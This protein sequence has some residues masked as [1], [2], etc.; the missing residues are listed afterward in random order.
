MAQSGWSAAFYPQQIV[1]LKYQQ[2]A[3]LRNE[4]ISDA[5]VLKPTRPF[6]ALHPIKISQ[7]SMPSV[8]KMVVADDVEIPT[9]FRNG[10][11]LT[12]YLGSGNAQILSAFD[13]G[14]LRGIRLQMPEGSR[15]YGAG[16]RATS[17][18]RTG[19]RVS[20]YN[21]PQYGYE[22]GQDQ[23]NYSVPMVITSAGYGLFFDNPSK[24]YIDF[25]KTNAGILEAG[26]ESGSIDVYVIPGPEIGKVVERFSLLTGRQ[27]L[28]PRWV[29]GNFVSRFGYR[30]ETQLMDV[31]QK[32]E[33]AQVP[34]D[35][36]IIDVFWFGDS[37]QGTLGNLAWQ[38]NHWPAP[39]KMMANLKKKNLNTI[40]VTEPFFLK[41][42]KNFTSSLPFLATDSTNKPFMLTDFYFGYGG[43]LDIF[44]PAARQWFWQFYKQQTDAGVAGWW[45][46]LGEPEKHPAS[47][48]HQITGLGVNRK[49]SA[50]EVH[51]L[52]G[53]RWSEMLFS[54]WQ[55]QYPNRR[56]FFLNR[57][58]FAGSQRFSIFPWTG[59]VSRSW[60]GFRAQLP[61]LQ[62]MSLSSVPYIHSDAGGFSMTGED[63]PELY[64]RWLQFAAWTPIFRPH[65]TALGT[66]L[67]PKG[68]LDL[69]SEPVF[70]PEPIVALAKK[71]IED[72]YQLLPYNYTLAWE[73][74]T[75][76]KP[77]M[78]PMFYNDTEDENLEKAND[79]YFWGEAF[80]VAPVLFK[81][82]ID[83]KL[84]LPKGLWYNW[85]DLSIRQG[86]RWIKESVTQK[87][88]P[89]FVKAGSFIPLWKDH[90]TSIAK[91]Q[92]DCPLSIQYFPDINSSSYTFFDDDGKSANSLVKKLGCQ[93]I[94]FN[95][96]PSPNQLNISM[97][98]VQWPTAF[99]RKLI[100]E[101]PVDLMNGKWLYQGKKIKN[102]Q[103]NGQNKTVVD[104]I[105]QDNKL[106]LPISFD[107]K[108]QKLQIDTE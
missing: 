58:G 39:A 19:Q 26:F 99:K 45:G 22:E 28:P 37:I 76:G 64:L 68:V 105:I 31:V 54:N 3:M 91:Y 38:T 25:G 46:D 43:L 35:A 48:M 42:T 63:D 92:P 61:I 5:V 52:Y 60:S 93:Q 94:G 69:P 101:I 4:Q 83:R 2:P 10:N 102:V 87:H 30:N 78:R 17:L 36:V 89:V 56:L 97:K 104:F 51:N 32:M 49:M 20:L 72:R 84:Y 98:A 107:G 24:G 55:K 33:A 103:I 41:N 57:A 8:K 96:V 79:Q 34:M 7:P 100:V 18:E 95:A 16:E 62:S 21:A 27:P 6:K 81:N 9:V 15:W 77:L 12:V 67:T 29:F 23:L 65:G 47:M 71:L 80:L 53:H 40:L 74:S 108:P 85:Y 1:R 75:K 88:I 50:N 82:A 14:H 106:L 90:G 73:Q 44:Q 86:G 11:G 13:S 59:D 70:K 66:D